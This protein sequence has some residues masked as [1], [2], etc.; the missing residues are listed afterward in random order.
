[1]GQALDLLSCYS[2]NEKLRKCTL[3]DF[4]MKRY[5]AIIKHKTSYYSFYLPVQLGMGLVNLICP[6]ID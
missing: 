1:M 6:R 2:Q 5:A 3:D 4:N